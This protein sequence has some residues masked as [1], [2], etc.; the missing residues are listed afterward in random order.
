MQV[1]HLMATRSIAFS[2]PSD[3]AAFLD[4]SD[5]SFLA[6]D[7]FFDCSFAAFAAFSELFFAA[8]AA[9]SE[10][11][12]DDLAL[13]FDDLEDV[14]E[15]FFED[16]D[17]PAPFFEDVDLPEAFFE[18]F[19]LSEAFF[20]DFD[21]STPFL[22]LAALVLPPLDRAL[23]LGVCFLFLVALPPLSWPRPFSPFWLPVLILFSKVES[24]YDF[25][26]CLRPTCL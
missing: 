2:L 15:A 3:L 20:E 8:F 6:F 13:F 4:L 12:F 5:A 17:L 7:S 1:L 9:L 11:S 22:L 19:D 14:S 18:D 16:F 25:N 21:L 26:K 23:F 10:R 24:L